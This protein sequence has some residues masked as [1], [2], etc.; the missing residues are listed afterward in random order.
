MN[1]LTYKVLVASG[2]QDLANQYLNS[3]N[4]K[5]I[6]EVRLD[7]VELA[8]TQ[9]KLVIINKTS[10]GSKIEEIFKILKGV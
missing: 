5:R 2:Y 8:I 1:D 9:I 7:K 4:E 6:N 3:M 10:A